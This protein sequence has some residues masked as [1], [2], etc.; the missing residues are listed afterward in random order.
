MLVLQ[1]PYDPNDWISKATAVAV[2]ASLMSVGWALWP[3]IQ[4]ANAKSARR[5]LVLGLLGAAG[6]LVLLKFTCSATGLCVVNA[7]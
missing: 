6:L 5:G 2:G 7:L 4:R 1:L 3:Q